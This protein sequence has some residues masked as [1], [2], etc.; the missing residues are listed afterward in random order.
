[1]KRLL[2]TLIRGYQHYISPLL[3]SHC[4]YYPSCSHYAVEAINEWGV[5]GGAWLAVKRIFRC[6]PWHEGGVDPVPRRIADD[7]IETHCEHREFSDLISNAYI[8][9]SGL[10]PESSD[11]RASLDSG[12]RRNDNLA[13]NS[14]N[15]VASFLQAQETPIQL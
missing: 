13:Y 14:K 12:F 2:V 3:G 15:S 4:R 11:H 10:D 7:S 8:C 6:V 9:H 5:S 1:M